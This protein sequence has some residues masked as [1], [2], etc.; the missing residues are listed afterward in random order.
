MV[1]VRRT[2]AYVSRTSATASSNFCSPTSLTCMR[3][4]GMARRIYVGRLPARALRPRGAANSTIADLSRALHERTWMD[5]PSI[6]PARSSKRCPYSYTCSS[7]T[8]W[9]VVVY[10]TVRPTFNVKRGVHAKS[11]FRMATTA[12]RRQFFHDTC[13]CKGP[14]NRQR[15]HLVTCSTDLKTKRK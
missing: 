11:P 7:V 1:F 14:V 5:G 13:P 6:G 8:V 3:G 2:S 10:D 12:R 4:C 15:S 9:I